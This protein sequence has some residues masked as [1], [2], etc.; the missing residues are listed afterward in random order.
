MT[1][2]NNVI[3]RE[4]QR[5]RQFWIQFIIISYSVFITYGVIQKFLFHIPFGGRHMSG[6]MLLGVWI[7]FGILFPILLY[8][9]KLVTEV[10][11]DGLFIQFFPFHFK[12][13]PIPLDD[14]KEIK[15]STYNPIKA[16]GGWGIRYGLESNAYNVSGNRGVE[17]VFSDKKN[18]LIG[19][20]KPE[21]LAQ[22][23]ES[24]INK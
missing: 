4:V 9:A 10:R 5:F 11:K 2:E 19:S 14:L 22:A 1:Q 13:N 21:E 16:Y 7:L 23:I 20:Q 8:S 24:L 17:L 12:F 6:V 3:F 18:L 15:A